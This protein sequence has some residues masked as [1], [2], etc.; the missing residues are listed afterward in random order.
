MLLTRDEMTLDWGGEKLSPV[1]DR[2][3][4]EWL[5][6]S[7][8]LLAVS[9]LLL[10]KQHHG[11]TSFLAKLYLLF[12]GAFISVSCFCEIATVVA[13]CCQRSYFIT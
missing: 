4:L 13:V 5:L 2:V 1:H 9:C 6:P 8:H 11:N 3:L 12:L 10:R 7:V